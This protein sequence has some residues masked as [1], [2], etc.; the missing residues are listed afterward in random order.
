M[1]DLKVRVTLLQNEKAALEKAK[2]D[3]LS[4]V[5]ELEEQAKSKD[6]CLEELKAQVKESKRVRVEST[7]KISDLKAEIKYM[8]DQWAKSVIEIQENFLAQA[9]VIFPTANFK[10]IKLHCYIMDG[11]I[12]D[13]PAKEDN[14]ADLE[15]DPIN[16][17]VDNQAFDPFCCQSL[18]ILC[19]P[20]C[21]LL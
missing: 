17:K 20:F 15:S 7:K 9:K 21:G 5:E 19:M 6:Q 4:K 8:E 18:C 12:V 3:L 2:Q 10:K 14:D 11:R 13:F 1:K 16:Q